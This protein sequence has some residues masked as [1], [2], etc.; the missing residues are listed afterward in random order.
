MFKNHFKKELPVY[1]RNF[2]ITNLY[3]N[4]NVLS[5]DVL[6]SKELTACNYNCKGLR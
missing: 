2:K 5:I 3:L 6:M 4:F 1:I